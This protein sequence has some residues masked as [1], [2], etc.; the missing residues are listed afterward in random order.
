M[1]DKITDQ[2]TIIKNEDYKN[3]ISDIKEEEIE[4]KENVSNPPIQILNSNINIRDKL[5]KDKNLLIKISEREKGKTLIKN[6]LDNENI[7]KRLNNFINYS[8]ISMHNRYYSTNTSKNF[9]R[10]NFI[11]KLNYNKNRDNNL[12]N[13]NN[14]IQYNNK[15]NNN[16]NNYYFNENQIRPFSFTSRTNNFKNNCI[17]KGLNYILGNT[18]LNN[19]NQKGKMDGYDYK[20]YNRGKRNNYVNKNIFFNNINNIKKFNSFQNNDIMLNNNLN[21]IKEVQIINSNCNEN[22]QYPISPNSS[23]QKV[24]LMNDIFNLNNLDINIMKISNDLINFIGNKINNNL[25]QPSFNNNINNVINVEP[26]SYET[27]LKI[28]NSHNSD[29]VNYYK[30]NSNMAYNNIGLNMNMSMK[31][32]PFFG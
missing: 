17:N 16:N 1:K 13:E 14:D 31:G 20:K 29:N 32:N 15:F 24:I 9:F 7:N 28:A 10:E 23:K 12:N 4:S 30:N 18:N 6:N 19:I 3:E 22:I 25:E 21:E 11:K 26:N 5:N 8:N 2:R 27:L